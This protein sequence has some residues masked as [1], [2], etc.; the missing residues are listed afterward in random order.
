M[1]RSGNISSKQERVWFIW[2]SEIRLLLSRNTLKICEI[3]ITK[4]ELL[5]KLKNKVGNCH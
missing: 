1:I 5:F 2:F 3:N 4:E